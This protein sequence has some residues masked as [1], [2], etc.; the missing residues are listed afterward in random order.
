MQLDPLHTYRFCPSGHCQ[1]VYFSHGGQIFTTTDLKVPVY[2]KAPGAEVP[3]CYC[4]EWT[5]QRLREEIQ[6]QPTSSAISSIRTQIKAK[7]CGCEVRNP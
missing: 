1:V 6:Q 4:F 3:I 7:R 5:W 2:Q